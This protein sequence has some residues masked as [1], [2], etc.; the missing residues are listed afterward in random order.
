M[1][2]EFSWVGSQKNY[3]DEKFICNVNHVTVGLFGG[4]SS[5]GQYKNEDG[6]LEW[7]NTKHDWEFV[8]LLDAHNT[9]ESAE[10]VLNTFEQKKSD[11]QEG[12]SLSVN[13]FFKKIGE[14]VLNIFHDEEFRTKCKRI[15]GETACII[16]VRKDKYIWWFSIGDGIFHLFHPE[17]ISLGQYQVNQRHFYQWVGQVNTFDQPVPCFSSGTIELRNGYN[18]LF[19]TTDGLTECPGK[20]Y[21]DPREILKVLSM[22]ENK[23]A[24]YYLLKDIEAKNVR[25]S[26]T[27]ISWKI[28]VSKSATIASD[29]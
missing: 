13:N 24:V 29:Q 3:V 11:I 12:L 22:V 23:D 20:L 9:A 25:D 17:L 21:S 27:I 10:L 4:N 6:C 8:M 15:K 5:A 14:I 28:A 19:L 18:Y 2:N 7:T 26:T 1:N 16:V